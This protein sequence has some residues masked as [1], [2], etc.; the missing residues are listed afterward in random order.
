VIGHWLAT[1]VEAFLSIGV[2]EAGEQEQDVQAVEAKE[3]VGNCF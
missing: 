2:S 1:L 3:I